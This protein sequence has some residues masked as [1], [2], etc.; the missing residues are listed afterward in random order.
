MNLLPLARL[1]AHETSPG[2]VEF[3]LFLPWVSAV[4]GNRLWVKLIHEQ[5]QFLQ[6]IQPSAFE[7]VH[8]VDPVFGDY[9]SVTVNIAATPSPH[10]DSAWGQPG[11]Y[12][13]RYELRNPN[14]GVIDWI[15]D[16]F[17]REFGVGKLSAFTLGYEPHAW[18]MDE[19]RWRTPSLH[20]LVVYELMLHE[21]GGSVEGTLDKLDYLADL[22][23]N[24]LEVMP[25]SNV[26]GTVDWGFLPIGYFGVDERFGKRRDFQAFVDAAHQRGIAVIVDSVYG[27]AAPEFPYAYVYKRL[28]YH[29]NPFMG[30]F[31][32]DYFGEGTDFS[33]A[34]TR[35][36]FFTVNHHW[37]DCYHVDGFRYDCVPNYWDGATGQ[38][39]AN[40]VYHTHELAKARLADSQWQ[41]FAAPDGLRLIQMAE[42]LEAPQEIIATTYSNLT[43]QNA[44]LGEAKAVAHAA[45]G[46]LEALGRQLGLMGYVTEAEHNSERLAK[47]ALQYIEN[48]DHSRFV[49][50][51]G[52]I[53]HD[54]N[55][56][57]NEGDRDRWYKVQPYL[58]ALL[59]AKGV[60]LLWQGQEFG[61]N[62]YVPDAGLG[63]VV[64]LR[65][66]RWDYF[67]D[68]VG[69]SVIGLVRKLIRLR[70]DHSQFRR[71]GHDFHNDY[72]LYTSRGV[73]LYTRHLD[74]AW[75]LVALNFTD[76]EAWVP[77]AFPRDGRYREELHGLDNLEGVHA[78][79]QTWLRLPS[80]Y[81]RVWSWAE[82]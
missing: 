47:T 38:G 20:D 64:L 51:F 45:P 31:A 33:R 12:V 80:N 23:V 49:C 16:P 34:Y 28:N 43:W 63:R 37:L 56:L 81:G 18:S 13:Y 53:G 21:F 55:E 11:R 39:Y 29:E 9:W 67:Y 22:G 68:E 57:L 41:R 5:D 79:S 50:N 2:L 60:P 35:D 6:A 58:I 1:G 59:T 66:V 76:A 82:A 61:E 27:H 46:A 3:G 69:R 77:Y 36:F 24:C 65:P 48:H 42:Q 73:L 72:H 52:V 7:L 54:G 74:D 62:Y 26:S 19:D 32:K 15:I 75:S 4:H 8:S 78:G 17:A 44:T 40:L 25:V 71:G 14:E 10:A 30:P 70:R